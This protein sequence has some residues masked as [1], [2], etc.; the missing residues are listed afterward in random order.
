MAESPENHTAFIKKD[1][2]YSLVTDHLQNQVLI[3]DLETAGII[4]QVLMTSSNFQEKRHSVVMEKIEGFTLLNVPSEMEEFKYS[5]DFARD[6]A[7][8]FLKLRDNDAYHQDL[9]AQNVMYD[10]KN[11]RFVFVD[12]EELVS[13]RRKN[14]DYVFDYS[15]VLIDTYSGIDILSDLGE[16]VDLADE[17]GNEKLRDFIEKNGEDTMMY[18]LLSESGKLRELF[19]LLQVEG[20]VNQQIIDFLSKTLQN[21]NPDTD[22]TDLLKI[23]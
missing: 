13:E 14:S 2:D 23:A 10:T 21:K 4:P 8:I 17:T 20:K 3:Q 19:G 15:R 11:K 22:F 16:L 1:E 18:R 12:L 7:R 5:V 6:L 9:G